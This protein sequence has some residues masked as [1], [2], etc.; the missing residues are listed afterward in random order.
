MQHDVANSRTSRSGL[1]IYLV[2]KSS[3]HLQRCWAK[4]QE[5]FIVRKVHSCIQFV[6][7]MSD[8]MSVQ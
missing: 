6:P 2:V 7:I 5:H 8:F 4:Q 3:E 1:V